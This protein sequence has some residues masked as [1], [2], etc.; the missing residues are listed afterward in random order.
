[1]AEKSAF[2]RKSSLRTASTFRK[3]SDSPDKKT[4]RPVRFFTPYPQ[5]PPQ[6][7]P[8]LRAIGARLALI[9]HP[10]P[11]SI[12]CKGPGPATEPP[13]GL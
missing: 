8:N 1:M 13:T 12:G 4:D 3:A 11:G 7:G 5:L 10:S 6:N 2:I 9:Y